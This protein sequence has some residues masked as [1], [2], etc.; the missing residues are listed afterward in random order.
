MCDVLKLPCLFLTWDIWLPGGTGIKNLPANAR[1]ARDTSSIPRSVR[2]PWKWKWQPTPVFLP[3]EIPWT[4]EGYSP[5]G[6][7][8]WTQLNNWACIQTLKGIPQKGD[9]IVGEGQKEQGTWDG[10]MVRLWMAAPGW[11]GGKKGLTLCPPHPWVSAQHQWDV[12][13]EN[14]REHENIQ[15]GNDRYFWNAFQIFY[16][17][18]Q[19]QIPGLKH[20]VCSF[21]LSTLAPFLIR[22]SFSIQAVN[23]KSPTLQPQGAQPICSKSFKTNK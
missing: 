2:F 11:S 10:Q 1:D 15:S 8:S 17:G 3:G 4:E 6:H 9:W 23:S 5:G 19:C 14:A 13:L 16:L 12:G 18:R 20:S 7:K 22:I 21:L